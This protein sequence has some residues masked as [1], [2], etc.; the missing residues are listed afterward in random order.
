[1]A[2]WCGRD[3][4]IP[5]FLE[6][7]PPQTLRDAAGVGDLSRVQVLARSGAPVNDDDVA[8][9]TA[10][11]FALLR[12]HTDVAR[13]LILQGSR[14]GTHLSVLS[15][16]AHFG[17]TEIALEELASHPELSRRDAAEAAWEAASGDYL[18]VLKAILDRHRLDAADLGRC[19]GRASACSAN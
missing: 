18:E 15:A 1:Y 19:L 12:G 2:L 9:H 7:G 10:L 17:R 6:K 8:G 3:A 5:L 13:W 14:A 16:A 11:Y 4:L